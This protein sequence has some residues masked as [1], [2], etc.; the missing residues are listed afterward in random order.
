MLTR[1]EL[2]A[3]PGPGGTTRLTTNRAEGILN[4]RRTGPAEVHLVG[5]GAGPLGGDAVVVDVV[6]ASG[7]RLSLR[8]VAATLSMPDRSGRPARL[9]LR[10]RV[11]EGAHLDVALEPLV[12]VRGSDLHAVTT[13]D[14]AAGARLDLVEV[15]VLGRWRE[16]P[17]RWRGTLRADLAG[18][19]WLRQ[20]VALG[21][22]SPVWDAL[23]APRVLLSRLRSPAALP[24]P[25]TTTAKP[26]GRSAG[27]AVAMPL[28]GGGELAQAIGPDLLAARRDLAALDLGPTQFRSTETSGTL[29]G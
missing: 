5:T 1:V 10:L 22:G 21:P 4:A 3:A 8:G 17:G 28:T 25:S 23:D 15:T 14:V 16:A 2:V 9:D 24:A 26:A 19:P 29:T 6:V 13:L 7:A 20:S 27:C 18:A 12:A 11:A